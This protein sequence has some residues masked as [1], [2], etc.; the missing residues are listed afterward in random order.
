LTGLTGLTG[1][2]ND[3]KIL[4][5]LPNSGFVKANCGSKNNPELSEIIMEINNLQKTSLDNQ[6]LAQTMLEINDLRWNA[7]HPPHKHKQA[8]VR[9]VSAFTL[10]N[11]DFITVFRLQ[12]TRRLGAIRLKNNT[13]KWECNSKSAK[14][15]SVESLTH[16]VQKRQRKG[17]AAFGEKSEQTRAAPLAVLPKGAGED[18]SPQPI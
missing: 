12:R 17:S 16:D 9:I 3:L 8:G 10:Y 18:A 7:T 11:S 6:P 2:R 4:F 5:V 14:F 15:V 1:F 13:R